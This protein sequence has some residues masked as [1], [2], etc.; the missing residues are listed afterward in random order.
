MR[1]IP[2]REDIARGID[3]FVTGEDSDWT[4]DSIESFK[5]DDPLLIEFR[6]RFLG[7]P[8]EFPPRQKGDPR[9]DKSIEWGYC[10]EEGIAIMREFARR[11][12]GTPDAE[13]NPSTSATKAAGLS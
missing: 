9:L 1:A 10:N 2:T 8:Q 4:L 6:E 12:R 3:I 11:L 5:F 7:L 13:S